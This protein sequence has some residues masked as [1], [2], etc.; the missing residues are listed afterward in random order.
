MTVSRQVCPFHAD[1]DTA[2]VPTG[3]EDS[4]VQFTC[5]LT[6]GHPRTGPH[7]WLY[8]PEP[9]GLAGITGYAAELGL[10]QEM[11]AAIA[12][13][14]GK[15]IEYGVVEHKYAARCP[16]DFAEIVGRYGH[17]AIKPS[18]YTASAFLAGV[19]GALSRQ[20][21]LL[22][23]SGPATGHWHYN[24]TISWWSLPPEPDWNSSK[25]SWADTGCGMSYVPGSI[26]P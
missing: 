1:E 24:G 23:H 14:R 6:S 11:P 8:V 13:Y 15:W 26:Y 12:E 19:L 20:G 25:L 2:G 22:Y 4:S 5:R 9:P 17:T 3:R 18:R 16:K 7:T 21:S 10:A